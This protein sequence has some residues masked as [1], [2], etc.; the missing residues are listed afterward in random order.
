MTDTDLERRVRVIDKLAAEWLRK[1]RDAE[2]LAAVYASSHSPTLHRRAVEL[3]R[4]ADLQREHAR[5]ALGLEEI[6]L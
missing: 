2:I 3:V 5:Q 6:P 1:A 4:Q